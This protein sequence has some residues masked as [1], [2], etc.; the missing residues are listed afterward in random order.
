[1]RQRRQWGRTLQRRRQRS[2]GFSGGGGGGGSGGFSGGG[3]AAPGPQRLPLPP[4]LRLHHHHLLLEACPQLS[5]LSMEFAPAASGPAENG[6]LW[7]SSGK[8]HPR[9]AAMLSPSV[10]TELHPAALIPADV[11]LF[12]RRRRGQRDGEPHAK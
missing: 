1:M 3:W 12:P 7:I 4:R 9:L 2:D 6:D 11:A 5:P 10:A 8:H